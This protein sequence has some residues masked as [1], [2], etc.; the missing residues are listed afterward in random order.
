MAAKGV[1]KYVGLFPKVVL[2]FMYE[3]AK[4]EVKLTLAVGIIAIL[5]ILTHYLIFGYGILTSKPPLDNPPVTSAP[6]AD[7]PPPVTSAP[8]ADAP[9]PGATPSPNGTA[10]GTPAGQPS[11]ADQPPAPAATGMPSAATTAESPLSAPLH[12]FSEVILGSAPAPDLNGA[13]PE[14]SI[15]YAATHK[16]GDGCDGTLLLSRAGLLFTCPVDAGKSFSVS[17]SQIGKVDDDGVERF[18]K[19]ANGR[20]KYHFKMGDHAGK[21]VVHALFENWLSYSRGATNAAGQ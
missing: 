1:L 7:A 2:K 19:D 3:K 15:L 6:S 20:D 21:D 4:D 16:G 10:E 12:Q 11:M 18:G 8:S 9:W 13:V 14:G 17:L 5:I